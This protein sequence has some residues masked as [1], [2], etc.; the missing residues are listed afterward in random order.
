MLPDNVKEPKGADWKMYPVNLMQFAVLPDG[1][2]EFAV[3]V[4]DSMGKHFSKCV[5]RGNSFMEAMSDAFKPT[6]EDP[7][8]IGA[9]VKAA[10]LL[11][12]QYGNG[13][14]RVS[15]RDANGNETDEVVGHGPPPPEWDS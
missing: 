13:T 6:A 2:V 7:R 15:V 10:F 1:T 3:G 5:G 8:D 12:H 4:P 9:V 11:G 14:L